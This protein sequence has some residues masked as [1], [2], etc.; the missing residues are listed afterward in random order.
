MQDINNLLNDKEKKLKNC[1]AKKDNYIFI[2][3]I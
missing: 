1:L 3:K 2:D